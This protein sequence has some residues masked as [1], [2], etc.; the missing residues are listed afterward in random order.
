MTDIEKFNRKLAEEIR[1]APEGETYSTAQ[2]PRD[3]DA[4]P[5]RKRL[6]VAEKAP[7]TPPS[8]PEVLANR[9]KRLTEDVCDATLLELQELRKQLDETI[10]IMME[11][12]AALIEGFARLAQ[13]TD[14]AITFKKVLEEHL[15]ALND[16][17]RDPKVVNGGAHE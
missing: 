1:G 7:P 13:D 16:S 11:R 4:P 14:A 12:K 15:G 3:L 6:L 5:P 2:T 8:A 10:K 9:A 17:L